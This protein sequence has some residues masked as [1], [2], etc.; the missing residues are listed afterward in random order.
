MA[1][2]AYDINGKGR[3]LLKERGGNKRSMLVVIRV[4]PMSGTQL[5]LGRKCFLNKHKVDT[6]LNFACHVAASVKYLR[7]DY[8]TV[9]P[10]RRTKL[11]TG[12]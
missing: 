3:K 1:H 8:L 12:T 9:I 11:S 4:K 10:R 2:F 5:H 6:F 7:R